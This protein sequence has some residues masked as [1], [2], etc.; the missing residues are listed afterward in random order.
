MTTFIEN[1]Q[2]VL[3][4]QVLVE[5]TKYKPGFGT[6]REESKIIASI[7]GLVE[8]RGQIYINI[9]PFS[10]PYIPS[11]SDMVIGKVINT[12]IVSW[13]VEI[14]SPYVATLHASNVLDRSFNP[15]KDDIRK[16][17]NIG[18]IVF[19]EVIAF[20]R[21][22]DPVLSLRGRKDYGKLRG[23][24]IFEILPAKIPRLIGR[25]GSMINLIKDAIPCHILIGQ[26]GRVWVQV[27]KPDDEQLIIKIIQKIEKEAH[28]SG[29]TDRI[30]DL[31]KEE[32]SKIKE[33]RN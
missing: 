13:K 12:S 10:G 3:P 8:I 17:F 14:G 21:T 6:Y 26:N 2:I 33:N 32:R 9:V 29:L 31:I 23:G 15:L 4:G 28:T 24:K 25:K 5:G 20:N 16:Y 30:K 7:V 22:R 11:I 19:G 27:R 18:D 1:R